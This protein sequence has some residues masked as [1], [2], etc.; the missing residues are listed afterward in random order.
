MRAW[1]ND[2]ITGVVLKGKNILHLFEAN[3]RKIHVQ[4][5]VNITFS[6]DR[7][8]THP[9]GVHGHLFIP[10]GYE[11]R[12]R[13]AGEAVPLENLR[14]ARREDRPEYHGSRHP[15]HGLELRG[16]LPGDPGRTLA[17]GAPAR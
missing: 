9:T 13:P 14:H 5:F 4:D 11:R 8:W 2:T 17:E 3:E 10:G 6:L 15:G 16:E 12:V 7:M 1:N